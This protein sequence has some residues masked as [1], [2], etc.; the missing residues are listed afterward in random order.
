MGITI[1]KIFIREGIWLDICSEITFTAPL[2]HRQKI[3][4]PPYTRGYTSPNENFEYS[5]P[6]ILKK[7]KMHAVF[8]KRNIK[9]HESHI[10][11]FWAYFPFICSKRCQRLID[12]DCS[13]HCFIT[14][15]HLTLTSLKAID[16]T[17]KYAC[18]LKISIWLS[19]RKQQF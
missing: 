12:T 13:C 18:F 14:L 11:S 2:A 10:H 17:L 7:V 9:Q 4:F 19:I 8:S 5:Y 15:P 1:F 16:V 3:N 6:L